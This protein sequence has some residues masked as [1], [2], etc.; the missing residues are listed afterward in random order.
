[1]LQPYYFQL[2]FPNGLPT[3]KGIYSYRYGTGNYYSPILL[4]NQPGQLYLTPNFTSL[5][6]LL[7]DNYVVKYTAD[8]HKLW[9]E[10]RVNYQLAKY[11]IPNFHRFIGYYCCEDTYLLFEDIFSLRVH[12]NFNLTHL[13]QLVLALI[14][15]EEIKY[16]HHNLTIDNIVVLDRPTLLFYPYRDTIYYTN[17]LV[18]IINNDYASTKDYILSGYESFG[19]N[20]DTTRAYR[21]SSTITY[22]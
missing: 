1:M 9:N 7:T 22:S 11:N 14:S 10:I 21:Y 8:H 16:T 6:P 3:N 20:K 18:V 12:T 5:I 17:S 4:H 13:Y 15:V 19:V 2:N